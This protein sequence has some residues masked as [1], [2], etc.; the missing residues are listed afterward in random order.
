MPEN[1]FPDALPAG[2]RLHWYVLER[3]LGQG[4]FGITYLARDTNL[5]QQVAIKEYLPVDVATRRSDGTVRARALEQDDRYR[6][7][8]ERFIREAR[9]LARFDHPHIVRVHSVFEFNDTAYMVMR[10]EEGETLAALLERR[11]VLSE[12]ELLRVLMPVIEGL[13]L[14]HKAGFIHRDIK[15]DNILIRADGSSVLLDFGSARQASGQSRTVTILV[16]P[17]YAP[18]EQYYS[19]TD[20]LGPWT[21]IY[22]LGATCYRAIA[23][24]PPLDA[25]SRSKGI[26]GST[27]EILLPAKVAGAGRYSERVL[28]AIDRA[29]EFA[30]K[31]RP[32]NLADWKKELASSARTAA[33]SPTAPHG[34]SAPPASTPV[35]APRSTPLLW[36]GAGAVAVIVVAATITLVASLWHQAPEASPEAPR[37]EPILKVQPPDALQDRI[38]KLEKELQK[39]RELDA[40]RETRPDPKPPSDPPRPHARQ[41]KLEE[42]QRPKLEEVRRIEAKRS[43]KT[44]EL[45]PIARLEPAKPEPPTPEPKVEPVKPEPPKAEPPKDPPK[46]EVAKVDPLVLADRA[47][48]QANY[49][50]AI[51]L[52]QPLA[53]T[54]NPRAQVRLGKLYFEGQGVPRNEVEAARLFHQAAERGDNE[55]RL[56]LGDMYAN[57]RGVAQSN[58]QAYVWYGA[59]AR[60]G[61]AAARAN[62]D[63]IGTTLQ[64]M[65]IRQAVKV[66]DSLVANKP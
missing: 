27:K 30:E 13:E 17:G 8:L 4:G 52:L 15:P 2:S 54:N 46:V 48:A 55:A 42:A 53:D 11:H 36:A 28:Q 38:D 40:G 32:Q 37:A 24:R 18:F 29:L 26:L 43:Q 44:P 1:A 7:G 66:I 65:E 21:D 33:P 25:I 12:S 47:I 61:N 51:A 20:S 31:D 56:R 60:G 9:T 23:G 64:S 45:A 10:F 35:P 22:G 3:V 34:S 19:G 59:A 50:E 39:Q 41:P 14:V 6:A 5:D 62:Q 16:A 49:G 58:F 57:G 63:R